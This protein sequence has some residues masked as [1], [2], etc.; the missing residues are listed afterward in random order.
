MMN[1]K[2]IPR[3]LVFSVVFMMFTVHQAW[4]EQE[5]Y[6]EKAN[7][8]NVCMNSITINGPYVPPIGHCCNVVRVSDMV[9][10]CRILNKGDEL[11]I[12]SVKLV[13]VAHDCGQ[14]LP[15]GSKCGTWEVPR[16]SPP[17]PRANT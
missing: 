17:P 1:I 13:K 8:E 15:V 14:T 7:V 6:Q 2:I 16:V 3:L 9:C 4:G 12:S 5:C 11:V 10:V